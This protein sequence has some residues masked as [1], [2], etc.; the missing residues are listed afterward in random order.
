MFIPKGQA[1]IAIL[2]SAVVI[3]GGAQLIMPPSFEFAEAQTTPCVAANPDEVPNLEITVAYTPNAAAFPA[4]QAVEVQRRLNT[5][6]WT[7]LPNLPANT[8]SLVDNSVVQGN[9]IHQYDYR[10]R[11]INA[12]GPSPWSDIGCFSYPRILRPPPIPILVIS[13]VKKGA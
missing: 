3:L 7:N 12:D 4:E 2:L 10:E 1:I 13:A 11:V 6:P 9:V 8:R 5:G